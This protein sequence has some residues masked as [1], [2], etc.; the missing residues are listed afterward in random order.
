MIAPMSTRVVCIMYIPLERY[1]TTS[2]GAHEAAGREERTSDTFRY[3]RMRTA[4][5]KH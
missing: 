1:L 4:P 2:D 3:R 5:K